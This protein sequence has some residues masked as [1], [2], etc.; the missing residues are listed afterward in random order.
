MRMDWQQKRSGSDPLLTA[1][2]EELAY[3][4]HHV[5][6][7]AP[8]PGKTADWYIKAFNFKVINDSVRAQGNRFISC[9]TEDGIT[10]NISGARDGESL[11]DGNGD[12]HWGLEH[13]GIAVDDMTAEIARLEGLGAK[14]V[15]G[16]TGAPGG[17]TIAFIIAPDDTRIELLQVP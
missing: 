9:Q 4:F 2:E 12:V 13:F 10:V 3:S 15:E 8:D 14:L 6:L 1:E 17:P 16:P 7:K 11:D 5:H